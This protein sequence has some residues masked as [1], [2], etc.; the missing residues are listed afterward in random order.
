MKAKEELNGYD[1]SRDWFDWSFE[2]TELIN[3]NHT[4]LYFFCIDLCNRLGWKERFGMPTCSSMEA[5]GIKNY[6]TYSKAFNDLVEWG[7]ITVI[8]KSKNQYSAT[9]IALVKNTKANTK[10]LTKASPKHIPKQV[11][12]IVDIDKLENNKTRKL[13]N[14]NIPLVPKGN[15][16]EKN[17]KNDFDIY[18]EELRSAYLEI[19]NDA[20]WIKQQES[21]YQNVDILKSIEKA[22]VNYWAT[23]TGWKKKKQSKISEINWKSTFGNAISLNKVYKNG[24]S[25]LQSTTGFGNS[26]N[27]QNTRRTSPEDKREKLRGLGD[28]AEAILQNS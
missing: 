13:E 26:E 22:C 18:V 6:K 1:L 5:I 16:S 27:K 12:S 8:E 9:I 4:A 7:F 11:Q 25:N 24:N 23:P 14:N 15:E 20:E 19:Q 21:F 28:M 10:A 2:H 17:W 3:P